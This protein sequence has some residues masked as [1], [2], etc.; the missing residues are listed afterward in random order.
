MSDWRKAQI[1]FYEIGDKISAEKK[2]LSADGK[3]ANFHPDIMTLA[4]ELHAASEKVKETGSICRGSWNTLN[5]FVRGGTGEIKKFQDFLEKKEKPDT[6][7]GKLAEKFK[8]KDS[9][10]FGEQA[11][12]NA[13]RARQSVEQ[14]LRDLERNMQ[15]WGNR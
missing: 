6:K 7:L 14:V 2:K 13:T 12:G 4:A 11:V 8:S 10:P 1:R 15:Y 5:E 9:L 3:D